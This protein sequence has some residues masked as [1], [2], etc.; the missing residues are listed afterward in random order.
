MA[1]DRATLRRLIGSLVAGYGRL[2]GAVAAL[3]IDEGVIE[4][5][6]QSLELAEAALRY[7]AARGAGT[8]WPAQIAV[9]GPTQT[10]KSTVVNLLLGQPL[11]EVSP[12]AGFTVQPH[13]FWMRAN[14][15]EDA[16]TASLLPGWHRSAAPL[17]R[18]DLA[19]YRLCPVPPMP[20]LGPCV[21]W[22]T[23][24][25]DSLAARR[26]ARGVLEVGALADVYLLVLSE[27]KYSDLSVWRFLELMAP[28]ARPLVIALN[29]LTAG[30]E[31]TVL[32]SLRER[33]AQRGQAWGRVPIV[34]LPYMETDQRSVPD[35]WVPQ[36]LRDAV[37]SGLAAAR[38]RGA[39]SAGV[40]ALLRRHWD[41]WL[42]PVH[43]E[44]DARAEWHRMVDGAAHEFLAAYT[45]DYLE[46]P[47][48]YDSFRRAAVELLN[49]LELPRVGGLVTRARQL[50]TWPARQVLKVGRGWR[51][52]R[53]RLGSRP[54][55]LAVES[56]VLLDT[57]DTLLAGLQR[58]VGRRCRPAT[59]GYVFWTLLQCKL[60]AELPRVRQ[61]CEQAVALHHERVTDE[62]HAAA[63]ELY[64]ELQKSPRR[65]AALRTARAVIDAG[66]ILLAVKTGGLSLLDAVWA[67]ATFA[68][69]SLLME[70]VTGLELGHA[71]R[72]LKRRQRAEV[73]HDVVA[74]TL[75]PQLQNMA[76]G[77][78]GAGLFGITAGAL[79]EAATALAR[80][81]GQR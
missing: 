11:A 2:R 6:F 58:E 13:G 61:V 41:A 14:D 68:V 56:A 66:S 53:R 24:D 46:H 1:E 37:Q 27:E 20:S 17:A 62:V 40:R 80:W 63:N 29:K 43:A 30:A 33:L 35:G 51:A 7:D 54:H 12:L 77:L 55:T 3:G 5:R 50:V 65:L 39:R 73:E 47:Q 19:A 67:P 9:L 10:G 26:Y 18:A 71:A 8:H 4:E 22:D 59:T 70:G 52:Q 45:R 76:E 78:V 79:Q 34:T 74:R 36:P 21:V 57:L 42:A 44:H 32:A 64:A 69:S 81:E 60:D 72:E 23:P 48:R 31:Q 16:W 28:L 25:F 49:L 15:D 38:D 75:T